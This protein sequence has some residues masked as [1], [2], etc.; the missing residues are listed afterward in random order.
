MWLIGLI[1]VFYTLPLMGQEDAKSII[2]K[3]EDNMRGTSSFTEM[4]MTTVRP[5]YTR[6]ITMKTWTKGEN[7]SL[8]LITAP[9]RDK[10]TAYLKRAKEIWNYVPNI[11]RM[12]K[13]PPSMMS[14]SWMGS[15]FTN[16]D[17][18]NESSNINDFEHKIVGQVLYEAYDCWIIEMIP[19]PTSS[20][21]YGKVKMWVAKDLYLQLKVEN[22]DENDFLV[23]TILFKDIKSMGG[24]K[25]PTYM[26]IK[27]EDKKSNKTIIQYLNAQFDIKIEDDFFSVQNLKNIK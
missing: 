27:P 18:V 24:K 1:T 23:S 2:K 12:I 26:E 20:I 22:Y 19:K 6:E 7:F 9:A 25:I 8:I 5:R 13:M 15:D 21:V 4:T 16:D 11:D 10:G 17:L 3:M 14:Q